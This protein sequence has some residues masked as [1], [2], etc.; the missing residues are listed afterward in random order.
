MHPRG[1]RCAGRQPA[2]AAHALAPIAARGEHLGQLLTAIFVLFLALAQGAEDRKVTAAMG[3]M[4]AGAIALGT[5]EGLAM[6]L[7]GDGG[8]FS[9]ATIAGFLG[10]TVWLIATGAGL[11]RA[12]AAKV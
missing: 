9:L 5:G 6:A 4:T 7:G 11:I 12:S 3:L 8:P 10:L 2:G 1:G